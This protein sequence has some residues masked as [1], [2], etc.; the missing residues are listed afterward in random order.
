[1]GAMKAYQ[2]LKHVAAAIWSFCEGGRDE[3]NLMTRLLLHIQLPNFLT[4]LNGLASFH[5]RC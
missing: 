2:R 5:E 3:H 4:S 1:M